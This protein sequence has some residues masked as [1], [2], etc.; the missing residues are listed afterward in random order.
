MGNVNQA[1]E[2]TPSLFNHRHNDVSNVCYVSSAPDVNARYTVRSAREATL[3]SS[4]IQL[5]YPEGQGGSDGGHLAPMG[6]SPA[7]LPG[8][9]QLG[10]G[11]L[12]HALLL[13]QSVVQGLR[14]ERAHHEEKAREKAARKE[15]RLL[16]R[17]LDKVF[18]MVFCALTATVTL[19]VYITIA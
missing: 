16:A 3:D 17:F 2:L 18:L 4:S 15:W 9:E 8:E 11:G 6:A 7:C 1:I 12:T 10:D 13:Y 19:Y 14:A 5:S